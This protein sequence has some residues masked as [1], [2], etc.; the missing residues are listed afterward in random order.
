VPDTPE[1]REGLSFAANTPHE[2]DSEEAERI[3]T[4][5]RQGGVA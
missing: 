1:T 4:E 5:A 3:R 2:G